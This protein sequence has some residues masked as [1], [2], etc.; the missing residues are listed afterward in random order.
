M[1]EKPNI[2]SPFTFPMKKK[3]NDKQIK[4]R[5]IMS[6]KLTIILIT[7]TTKDESRCLEFNIPYKGISVITLHSI[8]VMELHELHL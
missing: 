6:N 8:V 3:E 4:I 1:K 5:D 7:D 2:R